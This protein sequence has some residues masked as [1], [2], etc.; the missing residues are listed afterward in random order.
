MKQN[1]FSTPYGEIKLSK[2]NDD[3][4]LLLIEGS[5]SMGDILAHIN[6][7]KDNS[8]I[9]VPYSNQSSINISALKTVVSIS[10]TEIEAVS[11]K[12]PDVKYLFNGI[13]NIW[14]AAD[15]T[16]E[17]LVPCINQNGYVRNSRPDFIRNLLPQIEM[18]LY[19][20]ELNCDVNDFENEP[21]YLSINTL[22]LKNTVFKIAN[23]TILNA[24]RNL[25]KV[26]CFPVDVITSC[27]YEN[28]S[29]LINKYFD[30][31]FD[32]TTFPRKEQ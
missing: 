4:F 27:Y 24:K 15:T 25:V 10:P 9:R 17:G 12:L 3:T 28:A 22:K 5:S 13:K 32:A 14:L 29:A 21:K 16:E 30:E 11:V 2:L 18:T 7:K 19:E 20:P 6:V 31:F 23:R 8:Y 1:E 26:V